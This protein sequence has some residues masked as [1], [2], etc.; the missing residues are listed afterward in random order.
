MSNRLFEKIA[1]E[2]NYLGFRKYRFRRQVRHYMSKYYS[3][4]NPKGSNAEKLVIF[5]ADGKVRHG[6]FGDRLRGIVS[7]FELCREHGYDFRI[8]FISPFRLDSYLLPNKY[9]WRINDK[10]VSFNSEWSL[11]VY[12]DTRK[13]YDDREKRWQR[14]VLTKQIEPEFRQIHSYNTFYFA[15]DKFKELFN[16]L[17]R[18]A[19]CVEKEVE[20]VKKELGESYI[21][22]STRFLM[23]LGDFT[24]PK[25]IWKTLSK[26]EGDRLMHLC[27]DKIKEIQNLPENRGKK[28]LI[29][30]DS[31]RFL[32]FVANEPDIYVIPGNISH[33]DTKKAAEEDQLKTFVDF[34]TIKDA[35]RSYLVVGPDMYRS[36]N[37]A[38]RAAQADGRD[39]I[40]I[41]AEY[42]K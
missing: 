7:L 10:E 39:V 16:T 32:D 37:F 25:N 20:K 3:P 17:F 28:A 4:E 8:Y 5:M 42:G 14:R 35:E 2:V 12:N 34:F 13:E 18:P 33:I 24:E 30:S 36:S 6:G 26:E 11:P 40:I 22:I 21:S 15:E 29:T 23:L 19:P 31:I 27:L 41:D 9:D 1:R 38:K